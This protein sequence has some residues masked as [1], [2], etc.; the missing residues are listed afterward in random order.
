MAGNRYFVHDHRAADVYGWPS[1][2]SL[3]GD[4]AAVLEELTAPD[5][6]RLFALECIVQTGVARGA[7]RTNCLGPAD[8]DVLLGEEEVREGA[9]AVGAALG[10]E[11]DRLLEGDEGVGCK[12]G[13]VLF[14]RHAGKQ[15]SRR[16]FQP[17][18]LDFRRFFFY[19][20]L[21]SGRWLGRLFVNVATNAGL[22]ACQ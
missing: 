4:H 7:L 14:V 5:T 1:A 18:G 9:V 21:L 20:G 6:P 12:H 22:V 11:K 10:R 15:K 17:S 13:D 3:V 8:V 19:V 16:V 2:W